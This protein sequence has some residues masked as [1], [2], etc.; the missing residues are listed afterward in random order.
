MKVRIAEHAGVCFGVKRAL[1]MVGSVLGKG[2]PVAT[3]GPLIHNPQVVN[4]L[5]NEGV[6]VVRDP[7]EMD[8]GILVI[9]SHGTSK[10]ILDRAAQAG[11]EI[12]NATCPFVATVHQKARHL[13]DKG[14]EV[15]V[16]GDPGHTE[17]K[18][19]VSAAGE[20]AIIIKTPEDARS[21]DWTGKRV[22]LVSQT[23]QKPESFGAI[24]GY[25]ASQAKEVLAYNTICNATHERQRAAHEIA[26]TVDVMIVVGGRDSA[27]TN[28]LTEICSGTGVP[29]YHIE[30]AGEIDPKWFAGAHVVGLT[31]GASTPD[32]IIESVKNAL[33]EL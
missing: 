21:L 10:Q 24:A 18:G 22:G 17:V 14:Y 28:R 29:T 26:P 20:R 8:H 3:L 32:W 4:Q 1:E 12:L 16:A 11:L 33:E 30:T 5:E 25:I 7:S 19:I 2:K 9:P 13:S 6:M 23:T 27:N 31:A 15:V